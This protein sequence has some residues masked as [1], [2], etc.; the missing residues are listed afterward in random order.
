MSKMIFKILFFISGL[1]LLEGCSSDGCFKLAGSDS[2]LS[3]SFESLKIINIYGVFEVELIEDT[4]NYAEVFAKEQALKNVE[5]EEDA[6]TLNCYYYNGCFW[7]RGYDRPEVKI[8]Y[9]DIKEVN[10]MET[11]LLYS[12]DTLFDSFNVSVRSDV[13]DVDLIINSQNFFIYTNK[14]SG[15]HLKCRGKVVNASLYSYNTGYFDM[16]ELECTNARIRSYSKIDMEV[17]VSDYMQLQIYNTGNVIYK[18]NPEIVIDTIS[19]TGQAVSWT[20]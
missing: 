2:V 9:K 20:E 13:G 4:V 7:R 16:Y 6:D 5:L 14:S 8:H 10:M 3:Q 11:S 1:V 15:G 12:S 17:N 19:S 18:G